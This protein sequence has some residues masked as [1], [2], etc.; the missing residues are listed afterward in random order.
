MVT[1]REISTLLGLERQREILGCAEG[2]CLIELAN[3]LGVDAVLIGHVAKVGKH[4]QV[5]LRVVDAQ[6]GA[7]RALSS[8]KAEDEDAL[9]DGL[10]TSATTLVD[11]VMGRSAVGATPAP[12]TGRL[13]I[14]KRVWWV[15]AVGAALVLGGGA[16]CLGLSRGDYARL[17]PKSDPQHLSLEAAQSTAGRGNAIQTTSVALLATGAAVALATVAVALFGSE[18][19]VSAAVTPSGAAIS[20]AGTFP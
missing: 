6:S 7:P 18:T 5:S 17:D 2:T 20:F 19:Q 12:V 13:P 1:E 3:A 15:P 4:Y 8:F 9:I 14:P 16:L 11:Q 10:A